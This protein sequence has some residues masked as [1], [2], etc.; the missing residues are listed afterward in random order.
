MVLPVR[1]QQAISAA[2]P[3]PVIF[4]GSSASE[5]DLIVLAIAPESRPGKSMGAKFSEESLEESHVWFAFAP[6]S[7]CRNLCEKWRVNRF[8]Y[9]AGTHSNYGSAFQVQV[10]VRVGECGGLKSI[11][12]GYLKALMSSTRKDRCSAGNRGRE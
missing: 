6:A 1:H 7:W 12:D 10:T 5:T 9:A 4:I 11:A 3:L 2:H 8:D